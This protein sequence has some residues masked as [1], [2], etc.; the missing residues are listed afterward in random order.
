MF[1]Q[2]WLCT[3]QGA[4]AGE[5]VGTNRG[6]SI[7]GRKAAVRWRETIAACSKHRGGSKQW[8]DRD[9]LGAAARGRLNGK[10]CCGRMLFSAF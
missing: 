5:G 8:T 7:P 3:G 6:S 4:C 1:I 10:E 2:G 9:G